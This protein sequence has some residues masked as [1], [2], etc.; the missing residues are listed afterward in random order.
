MVR[1]DKDVKD[2]AAFGCWSSFRLS[3]SR[4]LDSRCGNF[5]PKSSIWGPTFSY[6]QV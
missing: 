6:F 3:L 1:G 5:C 4:I 2:A